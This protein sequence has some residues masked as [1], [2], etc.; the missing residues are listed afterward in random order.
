MKCSV[1]IKFAIYHTP[2]KG[3]QHIMC[4]VQKSKLCE[5]NGGQH[6][7]IKKIKTSFHGRHRTSECNGLCRGETSFF[8][9]SYISVDE[10]IFNLSLILNKASD[11]LQTSRPSPMDDHF[12]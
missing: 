2:F 1:K 5:N 12:R 10:Q 9:N 6:A 3:K 11:F 7:R 4:L 8:H